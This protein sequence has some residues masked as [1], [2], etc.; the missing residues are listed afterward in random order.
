MD[1]RHQNRIKVVQNLFAHAYEAPSVTLPFPDDEISK[2]ILSRVGELDAKIHEHATKFPIDKIAKIDLAI[3]RL[4]VYEMTIVRKE[5]SKVIINEA[6]E[7]AKELGGEKSYSFINGV[8]GQ[9][10][11]DHEHSVKPA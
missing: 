7:L 3:L 1:V 5:P 9:I 10:V 8:L 2:A 6:I 4:A 11:K